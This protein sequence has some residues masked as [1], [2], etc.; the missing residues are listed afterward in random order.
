MVNKSTDSVFGYRRVKEL[1]KCALLKT[2]SGHVSQ[3]RGIRSD[4]NQDQA[5]CGNG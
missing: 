4:P 3:R 5:T 1:R 2:D